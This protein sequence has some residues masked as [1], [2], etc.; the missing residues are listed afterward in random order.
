MHNIEHE[1]LLRRASLERRLPKRAGLWLEGV[2][3]R[4]EERAICRSFDLVLTP[5]DRERDLL[6]RGGEMPPIVTVPNTIDA[7][8]IGFLPSNSTSSELLFVGTTQVDANRNGLLWFVNEVLP[9]VERAAPDVHLRIV[10]GS[11]PP[12]IEEL[13]ERDNVVI[14]GYVPDIAPVMAAAAVFVVPLRVGG[15]TRLKILESLAYG[16]PTVSTTIGAEGLALVD[17]Q[18]LLLGDTPSQFAD[19]VV[20]LLRDR[21]LADRIR[22]RGRAAVESAY[23]WQVMGGLLEQSIDGV[24]AGMS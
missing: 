19:Q 23:T 17:G 2:K 5:S 1:L 15:G 13:G 4:R 8:R 18:D 7:E 11:P 10:G 16:V 24:R 9:V 22:H 3:F 12:E 20:A 6:D 14:S 21:A